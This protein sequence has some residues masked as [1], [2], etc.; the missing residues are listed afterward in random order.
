VDVASAA[1]NTAFSGPW[2]ISYTFNLTP[3][4]NTGIGIWTEEMFITAI[5]TGKA[6]GTRAAHP[7][8]D[9][10]AGGTATRPMTT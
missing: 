5:R 8:A 10:V 2:G 3:D 9:A 4:R 7:A 1:T 6:H